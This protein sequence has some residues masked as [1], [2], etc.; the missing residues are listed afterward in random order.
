[1]KNRNVLV[2]IFVDP[3]GQSMHRHS[4]GESEYNKGGSEDI[5]LRLTRD[6]WT[7]LQIEVVRMFR[8][9]K[10]SIAQKSQSS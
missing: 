5:Q 3:G 9:D 4:D 1:M 2:G 8:I 6:Q 10:K 7:D